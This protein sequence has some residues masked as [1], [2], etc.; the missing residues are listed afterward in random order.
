LFGRRSL[1]PGGS[2]LRGQTIVNKDRDR[3][4]DRA[5][6]FVGVN[7][8]AGGHMFTAQRET[9]TSVFEWQDKWIVNLSFYDGSKSL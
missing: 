2:R 8:R 3:S 1:S 6:L 7:C 5:T 9:G 4:V